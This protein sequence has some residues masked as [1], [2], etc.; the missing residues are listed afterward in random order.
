ME[1]VLMKKTFWVFIVVEAV[2]LVLAWRFY[3]NYKS[4]SIEITNLNAIISQNEAYKEDAEKALKAANGKITDMA[5][6]VSNLNADLSKEKAKSG[7]WMAV[8]G[9]LRVRLDS[10]V[11]SGS[12]SVVSGQDSA[13]QYYQADFSGKKGILNYKGW[14]RLYIPPSTEKA[15]H[16]LEAT[17]DLIFVKSE[18]YQDVDG[19]FKIRTS[20]LTE[21]VN[22][23]SDYSIDPKIFIGMKSAIE[24]KLEE[25]SKPPLIGLRLKL[26]AAT[27][28]QYLSDPVLTL[29]ASAEARLGKFNVTW[30]PF[31]GSI[32][33]GLVY[34]FG[35][36][37][38]I[39]R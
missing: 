18:L 24:N 5:I 33:A 12:A 3:Q 14:T 21:G 10:L 9:E 26:N 7:Y 30:Y 2:I 13:G 27:K 6:Q 25:A 4:A 16:H 38:N 20:S 17:F 31:S 32:S 15:L 34:E 29:D 19:L 8:A 39:F 37:K 28:A 35:I 23:V 1:T 11:S 22:L 36:G